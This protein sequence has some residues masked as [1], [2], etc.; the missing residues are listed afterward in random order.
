[1]SAPALLPEVAAALAE[2][3]FGHAQPLK[4][5]W[6]WNRGGNPDDLGKAEQLLAVLAGKYPEQPVLFEQAFNLV[7]QKRPLEALR[8]LEAADDKFPRTLGEDLLS[9]WGRIFKDRGDAH[10]KAGDAAAAEAAF[11]DAQR[12]YDRAYALHRDRFPGINVATLAFLRSGLMK[13]MA[14]AVVRGS[15]SDDDV[16][17]ARGLHAAAATFRADA[18]AKAHDVLRLRDRW[19]AR[20][21]DDT[22]WMAATAAEAH[23]LADNWDAAAKEYAAA[24][25]P[26]KQP[27]PFHFDSVVGQVRRLKAGF[28]RLGDKFGGPLADHAAFFDDLAAKANVAWTAPLDPEPLHP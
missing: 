9:L 17:T 5:A 28:E 20:L 8:I 23:L 2:P 7:R 27:K 26:D 6:N 24:L 16:Q 10:L 4:V 21:P 18:K 15:A 13:A 1:M 11:R 22:I 3:L 25:H 14:D 12:L 19:K